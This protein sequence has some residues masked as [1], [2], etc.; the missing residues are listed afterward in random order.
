MESVGGSE[1]VVALGDVHCIAESVQHI[2]RQFTATD[3]YNHVTSTCVYLL[4]VLK[5]LY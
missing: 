4:P 2:V 3:L 1:C 5:L